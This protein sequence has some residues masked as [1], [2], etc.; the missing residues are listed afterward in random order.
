MVHVKGLAWKFNLGRGSIW[1]TADWKPTVL[2]F[3]VW[4]NQMCLKKKSQKFQM[5]HSEGMK[6]E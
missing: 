4:I 5:T 1:D 6:S 2:Q 3:A